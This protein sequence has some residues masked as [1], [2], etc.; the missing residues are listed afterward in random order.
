MHRRDSLGDL[1]EKHRLLDED[2]EDPRAPFISDWNGS[3]PFARD[4]LGESLGALVG[5]GEP[6]Y[7]Y[8]D[9]QTSLIDGLCRLHFDLE[10]LRL[11]RENIIAGPGST[12]LLAAMGLWLLKTGVSEV[13]YLP[14]LYYTFHYFLRLLGVR[15]RPVA[16]RQVFDPQFTFHLPPRRSVLLLCDPVWFAGRRLPA[17]VVQDIR[18]WQRKTQ[19]IVVVDGSFQYL[20]W[21]GASSESTAC[22]E[23]ELTFRLICPTKSLGIPSFRF[24]YL[25]HPSKMHRELLFLYENLVGSASMG[26]L[27]FAHRAVS[28][29]SS[30]R[31]NRRFTAFLADSYTHLS[32]AG[33][34]HTHVEPNCGYFVFGVPKRPLAKTIAMDG[35]Y[36]DVKGY[37]DHVRINLMVA[38]RLWLERRVKRA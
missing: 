30:P 35:S 9:Q 26:D 38:R 6:E 8:F 36:F 4:F 29:L 5:S 18:G 16:G 12:S 1:I 25:L 15:T 28:V 2:V 27:L 20:Q 21:E 23:Q 22:L 24:A 11:T 31:R 34:I 32:R 10:R 37:S 3:H 14:P 13:F 17:D 7:A 19:S 33:L